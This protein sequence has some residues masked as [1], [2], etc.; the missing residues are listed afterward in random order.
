M[1]NRI[2]DVT[3]HIDETLDQPSR[4]ELATKLQ[5]EDGVVKAAYSEEAP[6]LMI[7]EYDADRLNSSA[8]L[9]MVQR[10]GVHAELVGL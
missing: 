3:V 8:L 1:A 9:D 4:R 10:H 2:V 6:H 7:V 5:H